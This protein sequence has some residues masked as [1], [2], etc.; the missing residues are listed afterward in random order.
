M[1]GAGSAML[2][3]SSTIGPV[4][5]ETKRHPAHAPLGTAAAAVEADVA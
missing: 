4:N 5:R 3:D 1:A 2:D